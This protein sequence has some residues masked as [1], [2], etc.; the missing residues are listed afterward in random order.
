[1]EESIF[2]PYLGTRTIFKM[3]R[4]I[5]RPSYLPERLPHRESH[6]GQLAQILATALRGERPSNI[7]IFGK[8]GTGKTAV[9]KYIENEFRKADGARMVQYLYLNCEIV[10]TPYGVLQSIGNKF[11]EN[12]HQRIPFTGLS[13]DRVYSLLLEKLD[14]EKRVVIVAL[15]EID[16]LVQKNGDDILYQLLKINDDL[17]KARVSL[18][19]ISNELTF[20][21]Y[22]DPRVRSRL[23]DEKM[24]FPPYNADEL[25]DILA[26]RSRLAFENGTAADG[27]LQL[28]A[29]L[30][31]QE[32][33]DARRALDL[34]RVSAELAERQGEEH[35][36]EE[37]VQRAKNKIE[38]DTVIEAVKSLPTQSKLILL[39]IL[40]NEEIGNT[41]LTTGEVYTTYRDLSRKTGVTPLTQRPVTD[42]IS[43]LDMLGLVHARIAYSRMKGSARRKSKLTR[44]LSQLFFGAPCGP[45]L[46][47][48]PGQHESVGWRVS[49]KRPN[50]GISPRARPMTSCCFGSQ[51]KSYGVEGHG[52]GLLAH[53]SCALW[54]PIVTYPDRG[55][56]DCASDARLNAIPKLWVNP[57]RWIVT[58]RRA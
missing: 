39:G 56:N 5:L 31:A 47:Q 46:P 11:I 19:G 14:E 52:S 16:K 28:I 41:K 12:F 29:A 9:V 22:L 4:E 49:F 53:D 45:V 21:E 51:A 2:Q 36:T 20:T 58:V 40:L 23:A 37:H 35:I 18:I 44:R 30:A 3:D 33:G 6:I 34:L 7:L 43:E 15:D 25:Y 27:V 54:S 13:T 42:L 1:M 26:E 24:V 8:T 38:L 50:H 48:P 17:S 55:A 57:I 32:H 10:D